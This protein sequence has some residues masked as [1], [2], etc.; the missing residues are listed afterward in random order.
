MADREE[1]ELKLLKSPIRFAQSVPSCR[2]KHRVVGKT[3]AASEKLETSRS[4]W[5]NQNLID[6]SVH[7]GLLAYKL[8]QDA[9]WSESVH[10]ASYVFDTSAHI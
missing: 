1:A 6:S 2:L 8:F 9:G 5:H 10:Y 4:I 3:Y 7:S